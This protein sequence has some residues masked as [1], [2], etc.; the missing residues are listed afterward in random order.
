MALNALLML[1]F[2]AKEGCNRFGG[3][4][5]SPHLTDRPTRRCLPRQ[6]LRQHHLH[7][8]VHARRAQETEPRVRRQCDDLRC[9]SIFRFR[10]DLILTAA[11]TCSDFS[12]LGHRTKKVKYS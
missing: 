12:R 4:Q 2:T 3:L 8:A 11:A 10:C 6:R 1:A 7:A 5:F 9:A